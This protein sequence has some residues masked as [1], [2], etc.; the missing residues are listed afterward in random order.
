MSHLRSQRQ[1]FADRQACCHHLQILMHLVFT[2]NLSD[3][4]TFVPILQMRKLRYKGNNCLKSNKCCRKLKL[5]MNKYTQMSNRN[6]GEMAILIS[7]RSKHCH[8]NKAT[9][10]S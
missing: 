2:E 3:R 1:A 7:K 5:K 4:A 8:T 9:F 6:I 10:K